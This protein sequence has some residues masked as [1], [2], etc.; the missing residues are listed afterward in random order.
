MICAATT[1]P[2]PLDAVCDRLVSEP[3]GIFSGDP[4]PLGLLD[5]QVTATL[6]LQ[7]GATADQEHEIVLTYG[8]AQ[9]SD[10]QFG[11][12]VRWTARRYHE[13]FPRFEGSLRMHGAKD[14]TQL[15]LAG[16]CDIPLGVYGDGQAGRRIARQAVAAQ[17]RGIATRLMA[18][19]RPTA[20]GIS[21]G[22]PPVVVD[23]SPTDDEGNVWGGREEVPTPATRAS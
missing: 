4:Q 13:L 15:E 12:S 10:A 18:G 2:L 11:R 20:P 17:L 23:E 9:G 22:V 3:A 5:H 1:I 7:V 6:E 16:V 8:P 21:I 19:R 14:S